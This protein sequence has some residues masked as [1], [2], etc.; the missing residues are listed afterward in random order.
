MF[1]YY[2]FY[3]ENGCANQELLIRADED[4]VQTSLE[5]IAC[6]IAKHEGDCEGITVELC[7]DFTSILQV[8]RNQHAWNDQR[9]CIRG[10]CRLVN[11][12]HPYALSSLE[13][14]SFA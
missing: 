7:T 8:T 5:Y 9:N 2:V 12:T 4:K 14:H 11:G 10:E 13:T 6:D 1:N 3:A